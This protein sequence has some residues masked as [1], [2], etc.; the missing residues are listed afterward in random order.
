MTPANAPCPPHIETDTQVSN[1]P[2]SPRSP[3]MSEAQTDC[4]G[5]KLSIRSRMLPPARSFSAVDIFD[6]SKPDEPEPS[7]HSL[8]SAAARSRGRVHLS[9]IQEAPGAGVKHPARDACSH[10]TSR[11]PPATAIAPPAAAEPGAPRGDLERRRERDREDGAHGD[12]DAARRSTTI[13]HRTRLHGGRNHHASRQ[14][15]DRREGGDH[16]P[17]D[18]RDPRAEQAVAGARPRPGAEPWRPR[19]RRRRRRTAT[20]RRS[21]RSGSGGTVSAG[22][23]SSAARHSG[24]ITRPRTGTAHARQIGLLAR[25]ASGDGRLP[26]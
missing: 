18:A 26:G 9:G 13:A 24:P 4:H 21:V 16:R 17:P 14:Q 15:D 11:S 19:P 23:P 5:R 25:A 6:M 1:S 8:L 20:N 22:S 7:M 3:R 10:E 2:R 12:R